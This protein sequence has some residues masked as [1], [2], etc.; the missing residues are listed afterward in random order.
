MGS[1]TA[2]ANLAILLIEDN[3]GDARLIREMLAEAGDG[4]FELTHASSL[5]AGLTCLAEKRFDLVL[6]DLSLPDSQ[7]IDTFVR[8][9]NHASDMPVVVLTGRQ[10]EVFVT[11]TMRAGAQDY[12]VKGEID[13]KLLVRSI[14]YAIE[15][16]GLLGALERERQ[17]KHRN[18]ENQFLERLKGSSQTEIA[19]KLFGMGPLREVLPDVFAELVQRYGHLLDK[20]L[21]TQTYKVD[22]DVSEELRVIGDDLGMLKA[23]PRDIVEIHTAVLAKKQTEATNRKFKAYA[24]E[25]RFLLLEIMGYLAGY[26]RKYALGR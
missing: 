4:Q 17:R 13:G 24:E 9:H 15:R 18:K 10:D 3:P 23:L 26:Y 11:R 22:Y 7:G 20:A 5:S 25:G 14:R 2:S 8:L 1:K 19:A 21:E 12:L 16:Q 6:L